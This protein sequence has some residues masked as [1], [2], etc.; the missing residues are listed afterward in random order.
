[1]NGGSFFKAPGWI[2]LSLRPGESKQV[3]PSWGQ[4]ARGVAKCSHVLFSPN[5]VWLAFAL[6]DWFVFPW[7]LAAAK[8]WAADWVMWRFAVNLLLTIGYTG[9]WHVALYVLHWSQRKF[10]PGSM[11]GAGRVAHNVWYT[12]LGI[13]QWTVWETIFMHVYATGRLPHI[14]DSEAFSTAGNIARML[15]WTAAI[16]IFRGCHFY[17]AHRFIHLKVIYKFVHSLHHR[18]VDIEPFAGLCSKSQSRR[19]QQRFCRAPNLLVLLQCTQSSTS[20]I[21]AVSHL[22]S[23]ST[24][25]PST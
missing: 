10:S 14:R 8:T 13:L 21:S 5:A 23:G 4:W 19:R 24:C 17:F 1:M 20:T 7:D 25:T 22:P 12:F 16:P 11:P 6:L 3:P 2:D 15:F 9:F 18:N